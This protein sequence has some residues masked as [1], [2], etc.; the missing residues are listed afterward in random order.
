MSV[1]S[2][3]SENKEENITQK[4][5]TLINQET[6][7]QKRCPTQGGWPEDASSVHLRETHDSVNVQLKNLFLRL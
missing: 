1:A 4:T 2:V 5:P 7:L 3:L 6:L